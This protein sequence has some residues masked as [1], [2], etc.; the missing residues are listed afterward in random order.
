MRF[1]RA[2]SLIGPMFCALLFLGALSPSANADQWNKKTLITFSAPV[3][4]PG[5]HGPLHHNSGD[6]GLSP[7]AHW[8]DGDQV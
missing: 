2:I 5:F 7:Q 3:E 4:I 1:S 6:S 8:Q